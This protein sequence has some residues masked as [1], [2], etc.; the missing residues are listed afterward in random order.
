MNALTW[1]FVGSMSGWLATYIL[2]LD[3]QSDLK[4]YLFSGVL[5]AMAAGIY[6][7]PLFDI[8]TINQ[9]TFSFPSM[10][11]SLGGAVLMIGIVYLFRRL[12]TKTN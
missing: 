12:R 7:T 2:R 5:G 4:I 11:V 1:L 6:L 9:K 3:A 8:E 10:L